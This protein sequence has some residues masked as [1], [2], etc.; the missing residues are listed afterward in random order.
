MVA[1]VDTGW[2]EWFISEAKRLRALSVEAECDFFKHLMDG[3]ANEAGWQVAGY[4]SFPEVLAGEDLT[5]AERYATFKVAVARFGF[6]A[7]RKMGFEPTKM[8]MVIP[9]DARSKQEG[10]SAPAVAAIVHDLVEF[11]ER[12]ATT[13]SEQHA[14]SIIHRH[15]APAPR[16]KREKSAREIELEEQN[17]K[18]RAE[19]RETKAALRIAEAK[20]AKF[21]RLSGEQMPAPARAKKS[22]SNKA[23]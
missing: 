21:E 17:T 4:R 22:A 18:L 5:K 6:D 8:V 10:V 3:E 7:V 14:Q 9:A 13:I 1:A 19:L 12:N 2:F 20:L 11:R 23:N 15:Y 16:P